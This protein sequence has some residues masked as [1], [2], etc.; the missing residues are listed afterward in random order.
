MAVDGPKPEDGRFAADATRAGIVVPTPKRSDPWDAAAVIFAV[1]VLGVA[2]GVLTGWFNPS[3]SSGAV[4]LL[5]GP[6]DCTATQVA[7]NG[8]LA[9]PEGAPLPST[10]ARFGAEFSSANAGCVNITTAVG[11]D[12]LLPFAD[13]QAVFLALD[14]PTIDAAVAAAPNATTTFPIVVDPVSVVYHVPGLAGGL[15]LTGAEL[16][17]IFNGTIGSWNAAPL[18]ATNPDL[19]AVPDLPISV[20]YR[21]DTTTVTTAFTEFLAAASPTWAIQVGA[22][23]SVRFPVGSAENSST[24][25]VEAVDGTVGAIGYAELGDAA[26]AGLPSA[27]LQNPAGPFVGPSPTNASAAVAAAANSTAAQTGDWAAFSAVDAAGSSSY[28]ITTLSV[29]VVYTDLGRAYDDLFPLN[30]AHWLMTFF[31]WVVVGEWAPHAGSV[32]FAPLPPALQADVQP[33]LLKVTYNGE[34]VLLPNDEG[35][36]SGNETGE[37]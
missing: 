17:G 32:P 3:A 5:F 10:L 30:S 36:E 37:F 35:G 9:A 16:A 12:E 18:V 26:G 4:P 28:P 23:P 24:A 25:L 29:A 22:G 1:V 6:Q 11:A 34:S 20:F 21:S 15:K 27:Q 7:L 8:S 2:T 19:S 33:T 31:F 14:G 13:K